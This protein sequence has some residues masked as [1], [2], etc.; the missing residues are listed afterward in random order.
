MNKIVV[1]YAK[2]QEEVTMIIEKKNRY[3]RDP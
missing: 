2:Y 3:P 1:D